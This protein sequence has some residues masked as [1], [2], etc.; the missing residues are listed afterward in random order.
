MDHAIANC[1]VS[2][3]GLE[4]AVKDARLE[5]Q[6]IMGHDLFELD[7]AG[8]A[9]YVTSIP[10]PHHLND[11]PPLHHLENHPPIRLC[12]ADRHSYSRID[13][14]AGTGLVTKS[15]QGFRI[16]SDRLGRHCGVTQ[17]VLTVNS[18]ALSHPPA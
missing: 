3:A 12:R 8:R 7:P 2:S 13:V 17:D 1:D 18:A 11:Y 15:R 5:V 9:S 10:D 16:C 14:G 4:Q 6:T